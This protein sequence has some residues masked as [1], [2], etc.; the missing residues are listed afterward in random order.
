MRVEADHILLSSL[1]EEGNDAALPNGL[2]SRGSDGSG[3]GDITIE[4]DTLRIEHGAVISSSTRGSADAG[5]ITIDADTIELHGSSPATGR[6]GIFAQVDR[7]D[8]TGTGGTIGLTAETIEITGGAQISGFTTGI[9]NGGDIEIGADTLRLVGSGLSGASRVV[10]GAEAAGHSG[11]IRIDAGIVEVLDGA[12]IL[13]TTVGQGSGGAIEIAAE[14]I[15]VSGFQD[16]LLS[17]ISASTSGSGAGGSIELRGG[18]V[19]VS[20]GAEVATSSRSSG[21]AGPIHIAARSILIDGGSRPETD[22]GVFATGAGLGRSGQIRLEADQL[23][24]RNRGV[25]VAATLVSRGGDIDVRAGDLEMRDG[26]LLNAESQGP[27]EGSGNISVSVERDLD[28]H[29]SG[30]V[31][32][33]ENRLGLGHGDAGSIDVAVGGRLHM[34][35]SEITTRITGGDKQ[36]GEITIRAGAIKMMDT[37]IVTAEALGLGTAGNVSIDVARKLELAG[38]SEIAARALDTGEGTRDAGNIVLRAGRRLDL[39]A[40]SINALVE[41]D[42]TT[43]GGNISIKSPETV[44]RNGARITAQAGEGSG[45]NILI[46][47]RT[48]FASPDSEINASSELGIDGTVEIAGLRVEVSDALAQ[49]PRD[50]LDAAGL[51]AGQCAEAGPSG[52][53][54][55]VVAPQGAMGL[56]LDPLLPS[57]VLDADLRGGP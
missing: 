56:D 28:M 26:S 15:R 6:S 52:T 31:A 44:L 54:S 29:G 1:D 38:G 51:L 41:G 57:G 30:I 27:S 49:L 47:T 24:L 17:K 32:A 21:D 22:T 42:E 36:A 4:A 48:F 45:G 35:D 19:E 5:N 37:S 43:T 18:E 53:S 46:Q 11:A 50:Y 8:A 33:G 40:S 7:P 25:V 2:F 14:R 39:K 23:L 16:D 13:A 10:T 55:F 20:D 12:Q 3:R 34:V 9:G